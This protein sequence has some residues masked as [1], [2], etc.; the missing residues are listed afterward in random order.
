MFVGLVWLNS[1]HKSGSGIFGDDSTSCFL[2]ILKLVSFYSGNFK[3]LKNALRQFISNRAPPPPPQKKKRK[4]WLLVLIQSV[5]ES[6]LISM[7]SNSTKIYLLKINNRNTRNKHKICLMSIIKSPEWRQWRH[8]GV[9]LLWRNKCY[10]RRTFMFVNQK[11]H[12]KW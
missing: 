5:Q 9:C 11:S 4:M 3:N 8:F 12:F 10:L 1:N 2:K 6:N 7:G